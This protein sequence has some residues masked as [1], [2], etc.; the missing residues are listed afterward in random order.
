M[1][2]DIEIDDAPRYGISLKA[3]FGV[4]SI[5]AGVAEF[6]A[7]APLIAALLGTLAAF[8]LLQLGVLAAC[9]HHMPRS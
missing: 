5:A 1:N 4:H 7:N 2:S 9:T 3:L 8:I 6:A